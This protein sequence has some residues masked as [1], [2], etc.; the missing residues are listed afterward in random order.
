VRV[1]RIVLLAF[2]C[3]ALTAQGPDVHDILTTARHQM[4]LT[5]F[6]ASGHLVWA[7]SSGARISCPITIKAHWF[8][9]VL[10]VMVDLGPGPKNGPS[11]PSEAMHILIEMHPEGQS[12]IW[13]AH[14]GDKAASS[15]PFDKWTESPVGPTFSYEDFLEQQIFWPGQV[16]AEKTK[17][18]ARD[19]DVIKSTPGGSDKTHY[20]EVKAWF[21]PTIDFPVY[22]EKTL[23]GSGTVKQFTYFGL[24]RE[25]G[26]WSAHQIE[27]KVPGQS[28]ST[29]LII[30]RGTPKANL[31]LKDFSPTQLTHF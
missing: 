14:P 13:I 17:F 11:A 7:P 3:P 15:L 12:T 20:A 31:T 30:D 1:L 16:L 27:I 24:R 23:K 26:M 2:L 5:D 25:G 10:R 8:S 6:S 19:C 29:L 18:G 4:E 22:V 28:G 21:D 9:G